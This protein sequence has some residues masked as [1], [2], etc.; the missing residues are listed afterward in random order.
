M[1]REE[2]E[3]KGDDDGGRANEVKW[4]GKGGEEECVWTSPFLCSVHRRMFQ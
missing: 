1:E 3:G 2:G 4:T